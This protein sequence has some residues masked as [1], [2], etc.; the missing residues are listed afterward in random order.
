VFDPKE[1]CNSIDGWELYKKSKFNVQ[2]VRRYVHL[3]D[4]D[5]AKNKITVSVNLS[6]LF[7]SFI[8]SRYYHKQIPAN[9]NNFFDYEKWCAQYEP[10][11]SEA[12]LSA[13]K[14]QRQLS[15]TQD[16]QAQ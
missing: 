11:P 7:N 12:Q 13:A 16:T 15:Q 5:Y 2:P 10:P 9:L 4:K 8:V 6:N 3:L 1:Y 14:R